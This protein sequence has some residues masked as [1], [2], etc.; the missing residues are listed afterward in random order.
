VPLD[1]DTLIMVC[2]T[3]LF[4]VYRHPGGGVESAGDSRAP[5]LHVGVVWP[6]RVLDAQGRKS[7]GYR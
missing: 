7:T 2:Y 5:P 1:A 3:R 6:R 4:I